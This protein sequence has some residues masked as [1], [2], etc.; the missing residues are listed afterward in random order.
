MSTTLFISDLH[1]D[2]VRPAMVRLFLQFQQA[3][4]RE[5]AALYILG[6]LFEIW[7]GD[8]NGKRQFATII[9]A[10]QTCTSSGI[11]IFLMHGNR[12]FL[13][14]SDFFSATGCRPLPDPTVINL[15]GEPTL[16]MHGDSLCTGDLEYQNFRAQVRNPQ[17]QREFL[18]KPVVERSRIA[19][20]LRE[21]SQAAVKNKSLKIMDVHPQAVED[22]FRKHRVRRM[23]H[24]HTH[25]PGVHSLSIDDVPAHRF[26]LGDWYRRGSVLRCESGKLTLE[27]YS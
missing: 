15:A 4:A 23:I 21:T 16:L 14:G 1:L 3:P 9:D 27:Q 19:T 25:Q 20:Q 11:P 13:L 7:I 6:D 8:D 18:S 5:C 24:G 10:L 22:A 2:P 12:D 17:W 26:V